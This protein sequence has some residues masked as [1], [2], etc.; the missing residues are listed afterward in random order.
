[1][2]QKF[3]GIF[4]LLLATIIWGGAFVAQGSGMDL[5]G[6]FT[7]Q[8][9]RA[10]LAVLAM[11]V[12]IPLLEYRELHKFRQ[13][14]L[15]PKLW[16]VGILCGLALFAATS[17]QQVSLVDTDPGKAG[18]ITA[19]YIL[20]VPILGLLL[21]QK[22]SVMTGISIPIAV[23]GM[24]LL[25]CVGT[26]NIVLYDLFL[27]GCAI[28]FAVQ[29]TLVDRFGQGL[30]SIRLNCVQALVVAILS[31]PFALTE[32]TGIGNI[33]A[34]S[35]PLLYSGV[36]SMGLAYSLQIIGQ[37]RIDSTPAALIMSLESVFALL[38]GVLF[39]EEALDI[40]KALGC[41]LI[42]SA[43]ILSQLP[44]PKKKIQ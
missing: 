17:L 31:I 3:S 6:P 24:Y 29:I 40:W 36:L 37:K 32:P 7:F 13:K 10:F 22:L 14:W 41:F 5:L 26:A 35:G 43:I 15:D 20:F 27:F 38:F 33:L 28:A 21:R 8:A 19:M 30:D 12:C 34:C 9:I 42:F 2:K 39:A 4:C 1:M 18:F 44:S 11:V 16:K 25:C 23:I